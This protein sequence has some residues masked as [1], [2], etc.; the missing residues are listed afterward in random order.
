M[1]I[2]L[3]KSTLHRLTNGL[4][5]LLGLFKKNGNFVPLISDIN[6][7]VV[8]IFIIKIIS[9]YELVTCCVKN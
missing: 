9:L 2:F 8:H 5:L 3:F 4:F 6:D 7:Y 1:D